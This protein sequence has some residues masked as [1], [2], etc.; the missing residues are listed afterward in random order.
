[1]KKLSIILSIV[2]L[3]SMIFASCNNQNKGNEGNERTSVSPLAEITEAIEITENELLVYPTAHIGDMY[4]K[5]NLTGGSRFTYQSYWG[6][7]SINFRE[8]YD[9]DKYTDKVYWV[10][11][12]RQQYKLKPFDVL[13]STLAL[14]YGVPIEIYKASESVR[15][16]AIKKANNKILMII[17]SRYTA[18]E[19]MR[20]KY[21]L[22]NDVGKVVIK[23][24]HDIPYV[25]LITFFEDLKVIQ[26]FWV[27]LHKP[28]NNV[29]PV[30][31]NNY[32]QFV[33]PEGNGLKPKKDSLVIMKCYGEKPQIDC[34]EDG[35]GGSKIIVRAAK[36]DGSDITMHVDKAIYHYDGKALYDIVKKRF[37]DQNVL[38]GASFGLSNGRFLT[39][40][41]AKDI[42]R[43]IEYAKEFKIVPDLDKGNPYGELY[44]NWLSVYNKGHDFIMFPR[45]IPVFP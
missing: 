22:T 26:K 35:N 42:T 31:K 45:Y 7:K 15:G 20:M 16:L 21:F 11:D 32:A 41:Q 39:I 6:L 9:I 27:P 14:P 36:P 19:T 44:V 4:F 5:N 1:M 33:Y 37:I 13:E 24:I 23:R 18:F 25:Q 30:N 8:K 3:A 10:D 43:F 38:V 12:S 28:T 40:L 29:E 17:V 34:E 2:F